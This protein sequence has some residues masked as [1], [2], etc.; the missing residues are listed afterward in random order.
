MTKIHAVGFLLVALLSGMV[1]SGCAQNTR[2]TTPNLIAYVHDWYW[3]SDAFP[4]HVRV[5]NDMGI[6]T[7]REISQAVD[8]WNL[9]VGR[10]VFRYS[11]VNIETVIV[12]GVLQPLPYGE[13]YVFQ[14]ELGRLPN[15]NIVLG[16]A[17]RHTLNGGEE[18]G[19]LSSCHIN[20]DDD[21]ELGDIYLVTLHE[22]GHTLGLP[23]TTDQRS[24]MYNHALDS[25]GDLMS[26]DVEFV[27][28]M[29]GAIRNPS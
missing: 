20:L 9:A 13:I 10:E 19:M 3:S 2:Q 24:I 18:P 11:K 28:M 25:D 16:L 7:H 12:V 14:K 6:I 1:S 27:Q 8:D 29:M 26:H 21:L 23:H 15:G 5:D 22:L 17:T 4:I